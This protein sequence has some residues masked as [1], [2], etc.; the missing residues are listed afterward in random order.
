MTRPAV[1]HNSDACHICGEV[2]A[3]AG[4]GWPPHT[5]R[6]ALGMTHDDLDR[7]VASGSPH[8]RHLV[9]PNIPKP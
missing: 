9:N 8:L 1:R 6:E 2:A 7:H 5:I 3:L 4:Y